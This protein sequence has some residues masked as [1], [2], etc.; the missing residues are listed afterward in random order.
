MGAGTMSQMILL[1]PPASEPLQVSVC[2]EVIRSDP[3]PLAVHAAS[4]RP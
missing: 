3:T 4:A 1:A 2:R